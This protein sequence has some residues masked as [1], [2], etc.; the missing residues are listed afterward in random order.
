M[1]FRIVDSTY[2]VHSLD[3]RVVYS[4]YKITNVYNCKMEGVYY[5]IR[6]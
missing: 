5:Y 3:F 4:T 2:I 6:L 1:I